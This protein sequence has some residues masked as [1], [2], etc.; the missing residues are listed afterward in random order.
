METPIWK[1]C[2][3]ENG[4][5]KWWDRHGMKSC[6]RRESLRFGRD[7]G[8]QELEPNQFGFHFNQH[9]TNEFH[10]LHGQILNILKR[11]NHPWHVQSN[12]A[13]EKP[14]FGRDPR[15]PFKMGSSFPFLWLPKNV[16]YLGITLNISHYL[17]ISP[18]SL[19]HKSSNIPMISEHICNI[20]TS[21]NTS[22]HVS[23][24]PAVLGLGDF[25]FVL[26]HRHI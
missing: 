24:N 11:V 5:L 6:S 15:G 3:T 21:K 4:R 26:G 19:Q 10:D 2:E 17:D 1:W 25:S 13:M 16:F 18:L 8:R 20:P 12:L 22:E 7:E 23:K 9:G 14:W